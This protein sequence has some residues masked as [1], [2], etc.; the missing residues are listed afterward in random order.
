M[1]DISI[2]VNGVEKLLKNINPHTA[3]GPDEIHGRVLT[4]NEN[5]HSIQKYIF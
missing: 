4:Q 2:Q 1:N 5:L 3:K